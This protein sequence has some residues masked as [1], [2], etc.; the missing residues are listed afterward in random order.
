MQ[1]K[2]WFLF[3]K[4]LNEETEVYDVFSLT[5]SYENYVWYKYASGG[6]NIC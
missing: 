1:H 4:S 2:I 6:N 5:Y 3:Y